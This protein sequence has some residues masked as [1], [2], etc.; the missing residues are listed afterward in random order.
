MNPSTPLRFEID[1]VRHESQLRELWQIDAHAY[2]DH[3]L[4]YEPFLDWWERYPFGS[5]CLILNGKIIASIGIYPLYPEQANLFSTGQISEGELHPVSLDDCKQ[6]VANWY[7]SG[8]VIVPEFQNRRIVR[9]LVRLG[10]REWMHSGHLTY[11]IS[12]YSLG[13]TV[14]GQKVLKLWGMRIIV[15]GYKLPDKLDL[16]YCNPKNMDELRSHFQKW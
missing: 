10:V 9:P 5:R 4:A 8:L 14:R 6:G 12:L 15:P 3:S 11:P 1:L 7:F 2:G 16:Y 13:Q